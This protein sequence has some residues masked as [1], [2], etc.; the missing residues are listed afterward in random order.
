MFKDILNNVSNKIDSFTGDKSN[1]M[2]SFID[3]KLNRSLEVYIKEMDTQ[4]N[5][6]LYRN[7]EK[8]I[9]KL[10]KREKGNNK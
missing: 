2:Y 10:D 8:V 4:V 1:L 3:R 7:K 9:K 6:L 5:Y